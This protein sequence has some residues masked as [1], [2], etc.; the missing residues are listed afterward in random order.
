MENSNSLKKL[1]SIVTVDP[2]SARSYKFF[3]NEIKPHNLGKS[4]HSSE[5]VV[6]Y[7]KAR[8]VITSSF[9]ISRSIPEE[10]LQD[11]VEI[12]AYDELGLDT[13][14]E[15]KISFIELEANNTS[16][17][18][19]NVFAIDANLVKT[20]FESVRTKT[21]YIDYITTAPFLLGALYSKNV[22]EKGGTHCFVYLQKNDSFLAIYRDGKYLYSKPLRYSLKEISEKFCELLGERVEEEDF[23]TLL[24]N[25]GMKLS[26]PTYQ[27]FLMQLF[28]EVFLYINDVLIF[29]KRGYSIDS[30]DRFY[31]G[32]EIGA[33]SG[34]EEYSKT[35]LGLESYDFNFNIAINSKEWYVDQMHILMVLTAQTYLEEFDDSINFTIYKRP[36]AFNK[37]ASGKLLIAAGIAFLATI[38]YPAYQFGYGAYLSFEQKSI[39]NEYI[40]L[41]KKNNQTKEILSQ[42]EAEKTTLNEKKKAE[43]EKLD[44]RKKL[45]VEIH[46]KK[47]KYPMKGVILND[48]ISL[49]NQRGVKL[50]KIEIEEAKIILSLLSKDEK[51]LTELLKDFTHKEIYSVSTKE[52]VKEDKSSYYSSDVSVKVQ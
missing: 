10:D 5:F 49:T 40:E 35:Y 11:A 2:Q 34:I 52:I 42:L 16:N 51:K 39:Y 1:T 3:R 9:E 33:I 31:I 45:L 46:D 32:S 50:E 7:I 37:R 25:E 41:H 14:T 48:L 28:G 47:N 12:K 20:E 44:F 8:D 21:K 36:P 24:S 23:Y 30:I 4:S 17:R 18:L 26:N 13:G 6:S 43:N 19:L 38:A 27:Q 29:A 22:L 15:Y